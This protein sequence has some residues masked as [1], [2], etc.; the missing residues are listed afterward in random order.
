[1]VVRYKGRILVI[2]ALWNLKKREGPETFQAFPKSNEKKL[3]LLL[4]LL[5]RFHKL[6][7]SF[8]SPG[9]HPY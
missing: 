1:M 7:R 6:P 3:R 4:Q 9:I 5:Q 8:R 2:A